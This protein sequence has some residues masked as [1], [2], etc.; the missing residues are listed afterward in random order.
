MID[1]NNFGKLIEKIQ[2]GTASKKEK[3]DYMWILFQNG[4]IT[5]SQY[6]SFI[7]QNNQSDFLNAALT[8]GAIILFG[9][10]IKKIANN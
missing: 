10:V 2:N 6:D 1:Y 5:K 9:A 4:S 3:E 7:S 8:I